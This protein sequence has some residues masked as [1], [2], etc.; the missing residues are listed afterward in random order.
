MEATASDK[1]K[2]DQSTLDRVETTAAH[3]RPLYRQATKPTVP[4]QLIKPSHRMKAGEILRHKDPELMQRIHD[5]AEDFYLS[6][7]R[8]PS[9]TEIA[10]EMKIARGTAY[11][12]LAAMDEKGLLSYDGK[13]QSIVTDR[14][15]LISPSQSAV[16]YAGSIPCGQLDEVEAQ[17]EEYVNLPT[18]IFGDGELYIIRA[19]GDSMINAGIDSGDMVVVERQMDAKV[20]EIV[21]AKCDNQN[22]L[23]R[24][25]YSEDDETYILHPENKRLKDIKVH[26]LDIQGVARFVI[27]AL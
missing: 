4:N 15:A 22:S 17:V 16:V 9:T 19:S 13:R 7:G 18:S 5:Y 26:E 2:Q 3:Y 25:L 20:G 21:V 11:K 6:N 24:L 8:S 23:K 10:T 27:K 14:I 1:R 12:Y